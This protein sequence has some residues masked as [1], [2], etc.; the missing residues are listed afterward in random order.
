MIP[1]Q[2]RRDP[3]DE[4]GEEPD[5]RLLHGE[6]ESLQVL[7]AHPGED[8]LGHAGQVQEPPDQRPQGPVQRGPATRPRTAHRVTLHQGNNKYNQSYSYDKVRGA[9]SE[10]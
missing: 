6:T 10:K 3:E 1:G 8:L 2:V 5:E 9:T 7:P 4:A